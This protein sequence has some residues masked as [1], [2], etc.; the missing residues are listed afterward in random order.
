MGAALAMS[1][2]KRAM[3]NDIE[4][5]FLTP[6]TSAQVVEDVLL[7]TMNELYA[8]SNGSI[9]SNLSDLIGI[10]SEVYRC[11]LLFLVSQE[12]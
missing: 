7:A 10:A 2:Q 1:L 11:V 9:H 4:K 3:P 5:L 6:T 12:F 8:G